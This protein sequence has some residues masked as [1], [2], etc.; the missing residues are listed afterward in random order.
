[1]RPG[2]FLF[3]WDGEGGSWDETSLLWGAETK[4]DR[5]ILMGAW[6]SLAVEF[7]T[8]LYR[9]VIPG[10]SVYKFEKQVDIHRS[11]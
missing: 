8:N 2:A 7:C 3:G 9:V 11:A 10:R 1:M 4:V 5:T 6:P